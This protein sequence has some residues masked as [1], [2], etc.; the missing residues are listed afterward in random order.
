ME[1]ARYTVT[2][3]RAALP[4]VLIAPAVKL[5]VCRGLYTAW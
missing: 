2:S 4:E 3:I 1:A 5:S